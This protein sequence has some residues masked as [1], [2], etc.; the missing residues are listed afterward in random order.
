MRVALRTNL[1]VKEGVG[2]VSLACRVGGTP[3]GSSLVNEGC[4]AA[5]AV[6]VGEIVVA[7][8]SVLG[9]PSGGTEDSDPGTVSNSACKNEDCGVCCPVENGR[10]TVGEDFTVGPR[11]E[12]RGR[13]FP[14]LSSI[15]RSHIFLTWG[16]TNCRL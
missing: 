16:S 12:T 7:D 4:D 9:E 14:P 10:E 13:G 2:A 3:A 11:V 6:V 8:D 1:P 15:T 5:D